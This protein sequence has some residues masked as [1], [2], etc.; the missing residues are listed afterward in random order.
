MFEKK[1][2]QE[3]NYKVIILASKNVLYGN[4]NN[5]ALAVFLDYKSIPQIGYNKRPLFPNSEWNTPQ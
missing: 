1:Y 5:L 3:D 4:H 2:E